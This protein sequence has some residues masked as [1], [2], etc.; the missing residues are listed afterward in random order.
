MLACWPRQRDAI[1]FAKEALDSAEIKEEKDV[2]A[3][4]KVRACLL[5]SGASCALY[6]T[7]GVLMVVFMHALAEEV[8][9]EV[10]TNMALYRRQRLQSLRVT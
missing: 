4:I 2:S 6:A 8:R 1:V 3:Y 10:R 5:W 7:V 9:Q